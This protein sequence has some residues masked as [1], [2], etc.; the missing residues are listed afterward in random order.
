MGITT[1]VLRR[2]SLTMALLWT[3]L[4]LL[5]VAINCEVDDG[6]V[7]LK[8]QQVDIAPRNESLYT[9][10]TCRPEYSHGYGCSST[11][12]EEDRGFEIIKNIYRWEICGKK[13]FENRGCT[14][15]TWNHKYVECRLQ[16][17]SFNY[18]YHHANVMNGKYDCF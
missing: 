13:C 3:T 12:C 14:H 7:S 18:K 17:H 9:T 6:P 2:S 5:V 15:W 8:I 16:N 4:A 10:G 11:T 1:T